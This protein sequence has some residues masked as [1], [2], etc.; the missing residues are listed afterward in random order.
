M[1]LALH[2]QGWLRRR[3]NGGIDAAEIHTQR[4]S[5][6]NGDR[7]TRWSSSHRTAVPSQDV[8][9]SFPGITTQ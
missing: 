9:M 8:V 6:A 4:T 7:D 2:V 1:E 5:I 3:W